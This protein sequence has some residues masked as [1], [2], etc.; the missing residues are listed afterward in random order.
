MAQVDEDDVAL[1]RMLQ[2][3][4]TAAERGA[5][6]AN[7]AA[8]RPSVS[9]RPLQ[10]YT[11]KPTVDSNGVLHH[12][13]GAMQLHLETNKQESASR[14]GKP[15]SSMLGKLF[16]GSKD[17]INAAVD[18][19]AFQDRRLLDQVT[20]IV[21]VDALLQS[22][23]VRLQHMEAKGVKCVKVSSK[24]GPQTRFVQVRADSIFLAGGQ[25]REIRIDALSNVRRGT[26]SPD[27][28][29]YFSRSRHLVAEDRA[30][31]DEVAAVLHTEARTLSFMFDCAAARDDFVDVVVFRAV[32]LLHPEPDSK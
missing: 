24:G 16:S 17:Q 20:R 1:A 14:S 6:Q 28:D 19:S 30:A 27:F 21:S 18:R 3:E 12:A 8:A 4:E 2:A 32:Q 10:K 25:I 29:A 26:E 23:S 31:L 22:M 11:Q 7:V 13:D 15:R 9:A 5:R